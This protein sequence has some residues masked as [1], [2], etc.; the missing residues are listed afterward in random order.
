MATSAALYDFTRAD[1]GARPAAYT[2]RLDYKRVGHLIVHYPGTPKPVGTDTATIAR[3]LR[4][5]QDFHKDGRGWSDIAYNVAV[6]QLGRVW[7]LRGYDRRD[8]AT[9]G[10][11]GVSMSIL[12]I[13]G[14]HE[15]PTEAMR[16]GI[17]RV[18]AE[19][20]RRAPHA[21]RGWHSMYQSTSCPGDRLRAWGRAGFPAPDHAPTPAPSP[22]PGPAGPASPAPTA[23]AFP[24]AAG[25]HSH[26]VRAY[27]GPR[28][29]LSRLRSVSGY[30]T[31]RDDLRVWQRRMRERGWRI[32]PDGLYG[33]ETE[34]VAT[35]FQREKGLAADGLIG[36]DTWAAAWTEPVT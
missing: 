28:Y 34:R 33:P 13:V 21:K 12:A 2:N 14:N 3:A 23:P 32:T 19:G 27:F 35:A 17:L 10:M 20:N 29:P 6:D 16:Q 25:C 18:L 1:W 30:Y 31:H 5:W 7:E 24:L 4:G 36:A 11:G 26:G 9:T 15:E 22:A 8:G